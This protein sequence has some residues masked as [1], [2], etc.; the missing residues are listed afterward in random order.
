MPRIF[1]CDVI[2]PVKHFPGSAFNG[3]PH[4]SIE[5][6]RNVDSHDQRPKPSLTPH[7]S[8]INNFE[9]AIF[10]REGSEDPSETSVIARFFARLTERLTTDTLSVF[11]SVLNC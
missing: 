11:I 8:R 6:L 2:K 3:V 7:F 5:L 9:E 10:T 1:F 4:S